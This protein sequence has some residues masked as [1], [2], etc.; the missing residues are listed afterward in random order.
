MDERALEGRRILVTG[1]GTGIGRA[2]ALGAAAEGAAVHVCGR[3]RD[4]LVST[5]A[6][7]DALQTGARHGFYSVDLTVTDGPR[8]AVEEAVSVLGGLDAILVNAGFGVKRMLAEIPESE[9]DALVAVNLVAAMKTARAALPHLVKA[10]ATRPG[11]DLVLLA[12]FAATTGFAGGS[13][14]GATKWGL[15]GFGKSLQEELKPENVRVT[16]VCP[17]STDTAFFEH[18]TPS[19][20]REAMLRPEEVAG[21]ILHVLGSRP[22]VLF[23]EIVLRPRVVRS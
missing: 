2:V 18:F 20:P 4:P 14:Y 23:E 21:A 3:R 7:I 12:S 9:I 22:D 15:R 5:V 13:V 19:L 8:R 1:G 6:E 10:A 17:A 16:I 11:A